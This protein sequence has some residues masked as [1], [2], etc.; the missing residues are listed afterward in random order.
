MYVPDPR[1]QD[2]T[3]A[4]SA[5]DRY[6]ERRRKQGLPGLPTFIWLPIVILL[7]PFWSARAV[8]RLCRRIPRN[9]S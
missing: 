4:E 7:I 6:R 5:V 8:W 9:V 1:M 3:Y 2:P